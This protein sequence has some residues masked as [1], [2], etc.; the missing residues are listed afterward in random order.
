[1]RQNQQQHLQKFHYHVSGI[2]KIRTPLELVSILGGL[3]RLLRMDYS[4]YKRTLAESINMAATFCTNNGRYAFCSS[5]RCPTCRQIHQAASNTPTIP[6][7]K[8]KR[9][10]HVLSV[11]SWF[12]FSPIFCPM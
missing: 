3:P 9:W 11:S 5:R 8:S 7:T 10:N 4:I 1:Q 6:I 2:N 12:H